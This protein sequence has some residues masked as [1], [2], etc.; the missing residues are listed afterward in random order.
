MDSSMYTI[1]P[2]THSIR[3][4]WDSSVVTETEFIIKYRVSGTTKFT[5]SPELNADT[6]GDY[7]VEIDQLKA[8]TDYDVYLFYVDKEGSNHS[9]FK[10]VCT[11]N[12]LKTNFLRENSTADADKT[13]VPIVYHLKPKHIARI[14]VPIDTE[15]QSSNFTSDDA[16]GTYDYIR[17]C[18]MISEYKPSVCTLEEKTLLMLGATGTGKSTL[19]NSLMNYIA[20]VS[21][22]EDHRFSI[23]NHTDEERER[24]HHQHESQTTSVTLYRIPKIENLKINYKV[25]IIDTPGFLDTRNTKG[26]H[27]TQR[28]FDKRIE[29]Q[30][31]KLLETRVDH[32]DAIIIVVPMADT[33]LTNEQKMLFSSIVNLFGNDVKHNI[34]IAMTKDDGGEATCLHL[35]K[36][37]GIPCDKSFKFNNSNV[38]TKK[39][40]EI[41]ALIWRARKKNFVD[42]FKEIEKAP[43]TSVKSSVEVMNA[44]ITLQIQLEAL[45]NKLSELAQDVA[46]SNMNDDVLTKNT[47]LMKQVKCTITVPKYTRQYTGQKSMNCKHCQK[48]CH[49]NCWVPIQIFN[50]TCEAMYRNKC[51][52]CDNKCD[53]SKHTREKYI[54]KLEF[55]DKI[56][57]NVTALKECVKEPS[58][59]FAQFQSIIDKISSLIK[60][61]KEK[62][63]KQE[64]LS[65]EAYIEELIGREREYN[66]KDCQLRINVLEKVILHL[67]RKD[68]IWELKIDDLTL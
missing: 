29:M 5:D 27:D 59:S 52:V 10:S 57:T 65:T 63:L 18:D 22:S 13:V 11:T 31:K 62:A 23:I 6:N 56:I 67:K 26:L 61:L 34:F 35:L 28:D 19:I 54:Y 58:K 21:Y 9:L 36:A 32:L 33:R 20:D 48:T 47:A 55:E 16:S 37:C 25:N 51:L 14:P 44:R 38:F 30:I 68:S 42:L 3:V 24:T 2:G 41:D 60:E 49:A 12:K 40:P 46:N 8:D 1:C 50:R 7:D 39:T 66:Q 64:E 43:K 53:A 45:K 4:K 17:V 15:N